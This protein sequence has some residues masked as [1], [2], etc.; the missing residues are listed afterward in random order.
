MLNELSV[1]L[2]W[3]QSLQSE[4]ID[5]FCTGEKTGVPIR[6]VAFG[7]VGYYHAGTNSSNNAN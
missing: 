2:F 5:L 4:T 7:V 3:D 6:R 1:L